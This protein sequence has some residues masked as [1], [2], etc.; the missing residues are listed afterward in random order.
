MVSLGGVL[1][2]SLPQAREPDAIGS[3]GVNQRAKYASV[4]SLEIAEE[5]RFSEFGSS[6]DQTLAGPRRVGKVLSQI[7]NGKR[8]PSI[9]LPARLLPEAEAVNVLAR[10]WPRQPGDRACATY[11]SGTSYALAICL[12]PRSAMGTKSRTSSPA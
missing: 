6:V 11:F 3:E 7:F 9:L 8:H 5:F 1:R 10:L 2:G 12:T 4:G